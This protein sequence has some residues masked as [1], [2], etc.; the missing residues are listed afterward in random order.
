MRIR[1]V[2]R[3]LLIG[4]ISSMSGFLNAQNLPMIDSLKQVLAQS[5]DEKAFD[6]LNAIGWEY[7][8]AYPDSTLFYSQRAYDYGSKLGLKK[9]LARP[10]NYMG[11]AYNY[12]GNRIASLEAHQ[13]A[14]EIATKQSDSSSIAHAK[15]SIG[16]VYFEQ[17]MIQRSVEYYFEA[18][19]MF[20][21]IHDQSGMAYVYQSLG[22]LYRTQGDFDNTRDYY[23][24]ALALREKLGNKRNLMAANVL[25]GRL[26]QDQNQLEK[27]NEYFFIGVAMCKELKDDIQLAEIEI[28][29]AQN[30]LRT[31]QLKNAEEYGLHALK[32]IEKV[33]NIRMQPSVCNIL[34]EIYLTSGKEK[35]AFEFLNR[36][37]A[38]ATLIS[39]ASAQRDAYYWLWKLNQKRGD[40][41]AALK[42]QNQ[43]LIMRDST[44][45]LELAREVDRLRFQLEME[46]RDK[47][48]KLLKSSEMRNEALIKQQR[49]QNLIL[50]LAVGAGA[51]IV[52][53][54]SI[55]NRRRRRIN[56]K[57]A[58]RNEEIIHRNQQLSDL[59]NE[60][61]TLMHIMVHDLK[62]PLNNIKGLTSL[63]EMDGVVN[64]NQTY[65][66]KLIKDS[67]Q[68][69]LE[70]ITD[71]LDAHAIET[72]AGL[73]VEKID[74]Q[75]F[76]TH[77]MNTFMKTALEKDVSID[78]HAEEITV[79]S[80]KGYL[81]RILD[82]LIS[83]AIKFSPPATHVTLSA[84]RNNGTAKLSIKDQGLG[85]SEADKKDLFKKFKK[86]SARPT[87]G[88][89]SNGL[90]LAIVKILVDRLN[91]GIELI[92]TPGQGSEFIISIP[93]VDAVEPP[94]IN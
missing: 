86:L 61:D 19:K 8:F 4:M 22:N 92:S 10:L 18:Q 36:A 91:G 6:L 68:S 14:I 32:A 74:L 35:S 80:D 49:L 39:D 66:L 48:N 9:N 79:N 31:N 16:R 56:E 59:N 87:A 69:G 88:E 15:N 33:N 26:Y 83:N 73:S 64:D 81:A 47:E 77:R 52:I 27:S 71:L 1:L 24:R 67:T 54:Q 3:M 53:L 57:L 2:N 78:L 23:L 85:F 84:T 94:S 20:E 17:G 5:N 7:R 46:K 58:L 42:Y 63:I 51:T 40:S 60:K 43:F 65:Y 29:L 28:Y 70:M 21:A 72:E 50:I 11:I 45:S 34:G 75:D 93:D 82:N 90:G 44:S 25:L 38:T 30:F 12:M 76:L 55:N 37:L 89:S 13:K 41:A 62:A